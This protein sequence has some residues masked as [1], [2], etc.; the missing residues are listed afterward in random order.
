MSTP[1]YESD[2]DRLMQH[3]VAQA[4]GIIWK[5][6]PVIAAPLAQHDYALCRYDARDAKLYAAA[7]LEIKC[8]STLHLPFWV[9]LTK[10]VYLASLSETTNCPAFI[11]IYAHDTKLIHYVKVSG[12]PPEV[13]QGGRSD[14]PSDPK[15]IEPMAAIPASLIRIA[16]RLPID[17]SFR[18]SDHD[19]T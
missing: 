18:P 6:T 17:P 5:S 16:T 8:R 4:L 11:A 10:W 15:A 12:R 2:H 13:V 9:S 19:S 14:R 7:Y 1:I 3:E